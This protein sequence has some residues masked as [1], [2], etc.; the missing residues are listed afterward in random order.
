MAARV[1]DGRSRS[2]LMRHGRPVK[3]QMSVPVW[4]PVRGVNS[5]VHRI[6]S[7]PTILEPSPSRRLGSQLVDGGSLFRVA[8][9]S[10]TPAI[11]PQTAMSPVWTASLCPRHTRVPRTARTA[12]CPTRTSTLFQSIT[13]SLQCRSSLYEHAAK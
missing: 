11:L 2:E 5:Q 13:F 6:V 7:L 3:V 10:P 4:L 9:Y 12:S 1:Q 8:E